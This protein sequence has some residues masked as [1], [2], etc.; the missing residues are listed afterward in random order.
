MTEELT[1]MNQTQLVQRIYE[2]TLEIDHAVSLA[3]WQ[4]AARLAAVRS[5]LLM[6]ISAQQEPAALALIRR[7]QAIDNAR[8]EEMRVT[9]NELEAEYAVAMERTRAASQYHRVA[10]LRA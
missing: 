10:L 2:L 4:E 7:I 8:M 5:P 9:R 3:D 6:S 1:E